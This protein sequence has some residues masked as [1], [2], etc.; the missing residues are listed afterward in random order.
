M[1]FNQHSGSRL[2]LYAGVGLILFSVV[3]TKAF[4][5]NSDQ[6]LSLQQAIT[7]TLARNP[8]LHQFNIKKEGLLGRRKLSELRPA[9]NVGLEVD[10]FGGSGN[11][12]GTQS[13]ET[14]LALSSVIEFGGKRLA[15]VSVTDAQIQAFND[16]RQAFTLD[17][18]GELTSCFIRALEVQALSALAKDT[19]DL[20]QNTLAIVKN[21]SKQGA[22]PEAEVK[23]AKSAFSQAQLQVN[24]LEQQY[25]R[26]RIKIAAYWGETSPNW[27][28][29]NGKID[30]FGQSSDFATLYDRAQKSPAINQLA[31]KAR[32]KKAEVSLARTQSISNLSWQ[33]GVR[34]FEDSGDTA[35][36]AG[37]SIPL[38]TGKRSRGAL[39]SALA[40]ESEVVYERQT[41]LLKLHVLLFEAYSQRQQH[42]AAV[43]VFRTTI[44]PDLN[45]VL[46]ST[47]RAYE[48]GRYSYQDWIA[49]QKELLDAKRSFIENAAAAS[50]NQAII[51][52]L[53]AEPLH[54]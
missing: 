4:A 33:L 46:A 20:A 7:K 9:L 32:L 12:A 17:V 5:Q 43:K 29:L 26:L 41:A 2:R 3:S 22:A 54:S 44:L 25:Q 8:Q 13:A 49:A 10:N 23:R 18:L 35:F 11:L 19:R 51:E 48:T 21:R 14:T 30:A 1:F 39:K 52:Q 28:T 36:T 45:A 38:S 6:S 16:H 27:T 31:S 50:I 53:I 47:Q 37:V 15:R 24:A 42:I 34:R 40:A